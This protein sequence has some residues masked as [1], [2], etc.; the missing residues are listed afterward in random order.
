[1]PLI[2]VPYTSGQIGA[3]QAAGGVL[4]T[5]GQRIAD[6]AIA[7]GVHPAWNPSP[8]RS[9]NA[10]DAR[11]REELIRAVLEWSTGTVQKHVMYDTE[12]DK[13]EKGF[14]SYH[15]GMTFSLIWAR[16]VLGIDDLA[17]VDRVLEGAGIHTNDRR[18]DLLG[19][20]QNGV[21]YAIEA[22]GRS[23]GI[24]DAIERGKR[25]IDESRYWFLLDGSPAIGVVV[26]SYFSDHG[27]SMSA[28]DPESWA[29]RYEVSELLLRTVALEPY[30]EAIAREGE[31]ASVELPPGYVGAEIGDTGV[32]VGLSPRVADA[33]R[34]AQTRKA[35]AQ[36]R[37]VLSKKS[38][39]AESQETSDERLPPRQL[40]GR[41]RY[42]QIGESLDLDP[43]PERPIEIQQYRGRISR[44]G[45]AVLVDE[46]WEFDL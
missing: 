14:A 12:L 42:L 46:R 34:L 24:G 15:I 29:R 4:E 45:V 28:I 40:P 19:T 2:S 35:R 6:A 1:M 36:S 5:D 41:S 17:H 27:L 31:E 33:I 26:A 7:V 16:S 9:G 23:R 43:T 25:Q 11:W 3:L 18:P 20:D 37:S 22:K 8:H 13:T 38:S 21:L 32:L 10:F 30:A 44:S 39:I